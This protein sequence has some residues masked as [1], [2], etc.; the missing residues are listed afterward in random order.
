M[1]TSTILAI[2]SML[3]TVASMIWIGGFRFSA[4]VHEVKTLKS[5][6]TKLENKLDKRIDTLEDQINTRIDSLEER[7][8][9][10][11]EDLE[12]RLD[13]KIEDLEERLDK[14]I[15]NIEERMDKR[16]EKMEIRFEKFENKMESLQTEFY[17]IDI[18]LTTL[19]H[20]I[21]PHP[22]PASPSPL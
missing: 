1:E 19:E 10:K 4:I 17:K 12:A 11:I 13:K 7:L 15:E 3:L 21:P 6:M 20:I 16:F 22:Y 5:D 18:R 8:D 14:K 2:M 9:R